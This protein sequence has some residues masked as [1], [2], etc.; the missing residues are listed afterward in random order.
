M[1]EKYT[2]SPCPCGHRA[3]K[4]WHVCPVADVQG[5]HFTRQQA[6]AVAKLLNEMDAAKARVTQR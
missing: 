1:S 4:D 3:C 2:V 5:V 6:E